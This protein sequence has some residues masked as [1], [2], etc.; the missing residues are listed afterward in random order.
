MPDGSATVVWSL[1]TVH[2]WHDVEAG[3]QAARRALAPGG[4][5]LAVERCVSSGAQGLASH[6]WLDA[7][8]EAFADECRAA[9]FTQV[10]V[11]TRPAGHQR[12]FAVLAVAA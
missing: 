8:A 2:H 4:R 3:L 7:Q 10:R 5:L 6:G 12:V 1:A 9:G 11:E